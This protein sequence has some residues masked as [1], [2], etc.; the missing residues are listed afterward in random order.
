MKYFNIFLSSLILV[1]YVS[2][3]V[4]VQATGL[5]VFKD[6]MSAAQG[7]AIASLIDE[8][9]I[10]AIGQNAMLQYQNQPYSS[11]DSAVNELSNSARDYERKVSALERRLRRIDRQID[12]GGAQQSTLRRY[13][14]DL[15][16][17]VRVRGKA[18]GIFNALLSAAQR[19]QITL[20]PIG[21]Q[22]ISHLNI[23][24]TT[25]DNKL[26]DIHNRVVALTQF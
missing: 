22:N 18:Q 10:Q 24:V 4:S 1:V 11:V 6:K 23:L 17:V 2:T 5:E 14:A 9:R 3:T 26:F 12:D 19:R 25:Q 16:D 20:S 21:Q 13:V 7:S 8:M 15:Y